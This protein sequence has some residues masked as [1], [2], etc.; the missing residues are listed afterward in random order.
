MGV[1]ARHRRISGGRGETSRSV[2]LPSTSTAELLW[3]ARCEAQSSGT[4]TAHSWRTALD[5]SSVEPQG[6]RAAWITLPNPLRSSNNLT[7]ADTRPL[8]LQSRIVNHAPHDLVLT[9]GFL[10]FG[11]QTG[12]LAAVESVALPVGAVCGT[13]SGA[14]AAALWIA[15]KRASEVFD[16]LTARPPLRNVRPSLCCWR[17][18]LTLDPVIDLLRRYLPPRFEDLPIP[19]FVGVQDLMGSHRLLGSGPLPEAVAASCAMPWIFQPVSVDGTRYVDGGAADRTALGPFRALRGRQP[20]I[21]HWV[22]RSHGTEVPITDANELRIVRSPR[23]GAQLWR[24]GPAR[25]RYEQT[26]R[27][28][29]ERLET[30][31]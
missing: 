7:S 29:I 25:Q 22:D 23:S 15:G 8:L 13:S 2:A 19:L 26:R 4:T 11:S 18:A 9:S 28:T 6:C 14:L 16:L 5:L 30:W 31:M 21:V 3:P 17:G 20:T 12:F 10:A 27:D 24:L 1:A